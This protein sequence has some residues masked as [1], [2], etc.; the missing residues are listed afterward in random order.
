MNIHAIGQVASPMTTFSLALKLKVYPQVKWKHLDGWPNKSMPLAVE[1]R[2]HEWYYTPAGVACDVYR[3]VT[4]QGE[5]QSEWPVTTYPNFKAYTAR[6]HT[7]PKEVL[8]W[9]GYTTTAVSPFWCWL[10]S[11]TYETTID[12]AEAADKI[13]NLH[14]RLKQVMDDI[15]TLYGEVMASDIPTWR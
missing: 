7:I 9:L 15:I 12:H 3:I 14:G 1:V 5:W 13:L 6:V 2:H 11:N 8:S 10:Y 4:G